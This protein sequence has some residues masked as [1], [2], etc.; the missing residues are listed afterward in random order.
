[1]IEDGQ[2]YLPFLGIDLKNTPQSVG[3]EVKR[4]S[5]SAQK[6]Y[7]YFLYHQ[8]EAVNATRFAQKMD[9]TLMT[10]SRALKELYRVDLITYEVGGKTGRSKEYK[11]IP[12]TEY[13]RKGREYIKSPVR[14]VVYVKKEPAGA[15]IAGMDA[16]AAVSM[17]NPPD[18]PVRAIS[19]ERLN[20]IN[21]DIVQHTDVIK[22]T[23][24]VE[25]QV[26]DYDPLQFSDSKYVDR[27]SLY[28]SLKDE[29]DERVEQALEQV[30]RVEP[31][32]TD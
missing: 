6:A 7:L 15:L 14:K 16:L 24:L 13:F 21:V 19:R 10:A 27:M 9:F 29:N 28:A 1:M 20:D 31:W 4:F 26:W 32:Y 17:L 2:M 11:R 23:K 5:I 3:K 30:L 18:H 8:K 22:D 25:L 12:D